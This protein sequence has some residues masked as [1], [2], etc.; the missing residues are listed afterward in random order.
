V[1]ASARGTASNYSKGIWLRRGDLLSV[2]GL[3]ATVA[4]AGAVLLV[5]AEL[6]PLYTV[7]VGSLRTPQRSVSGG[8]NHGYALLLAAAG[9]LAMTIGALRG[10][11]AAAA[12]LV[13][14]G[15]VVLAIAFG[16]DRPDTHSSGTLRES[17]AFQAARAQPARGYTLEIAGGVALIVAGGALL[18][19]GGGRPTRRSDR[20]RPG[21][22]SGGAR[23]AD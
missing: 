18:V 1:S 22:E 14:L 2:R 23:P 10:A 19:L 5:V 8:A 21:R 4:V 16:I 15:A 6:S 17:I 20:A 11:R 3:A 9:A 13:A 12:A 7:V